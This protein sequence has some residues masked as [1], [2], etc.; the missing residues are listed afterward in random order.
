MKKVFCL[1][2]IVLLF[3]TNHN[4]YCKTGFEQETETDT[5]TISRKYLDIIECADSIEWYLLDPFSEDTTILRLGKIAEILVS[6]TDTISERMNLLKQTLLSPKSFVHNNMVKECTFLPDIAACIY[7]NKGNIYFYYSFY[8][9]LCR[10]YSE[11]MYQEIDGELIRKNVLSIVCDVFPKD[12]YLRNL[13][14]REK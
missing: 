12:R 9:D 7:S 2:F 3:F 11:G 13:K 6:K 10:F 1:L 14:R 5:S 4:G 8:C